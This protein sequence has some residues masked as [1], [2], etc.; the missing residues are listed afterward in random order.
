MGFISYMLRRLAVLGLVLL[1]VSI[2]VFVLLRG[3]PGV[4]PLA[5]YITPGLPMS[6][7]ALKLLRKELHLDEPLPRSVRVLRRRPA[8]RRLGLFPHRG[9]ARSRALLERLPATIELAVCAS[10]S[11][12]WSACRQ[13]SSPHCGGTARLT[14]PC[15]SSRSPASRFPVFW[16]GIILQLVFFYYLG[17]AGAAE[18][19]FARERGRAGRARVSLGAVTGFYLIDSLLKGNLPFL[20]SACAISCCPP[21]R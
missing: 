19:A 18:S 5:A 8:P 16:V 4:D 17:A 3:M 1:G 7:D 20:L 11:A 14:S 15:E 13:A 9:A 2:V 10:C 12:P 21:S 6:P